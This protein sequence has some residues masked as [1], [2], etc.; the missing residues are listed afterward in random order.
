MATLLVDGQVLVSG[1]ELDG[2]FHKPY[3]PVR[4]H[5]NRASTSGHPPD[6]CCCLRPGAGRIQG[7]QGL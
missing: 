7:A 5:S 2:Q 6:P 4:D 1:G 3:L